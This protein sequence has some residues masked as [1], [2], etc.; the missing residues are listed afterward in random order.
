MHGNYGK[1]HSREWTK[2]IIEKSSKSL[3]GRKLSKEHI[4]KLRLKKIGNK[5]GCG[6]KGVKRSKEAIKNIREARKKQT[7]EN[8]W[9]WIKDRAKLKTDRLK[10]YDVKYK[11][12]MKEV[13]DRDNWKCKINN[14]DCNGRLEA[15]HILPWSKFPELRYEVNNGITLC[16]HHHPRKRNDEK[17]LAPMFKKMVLD[18]A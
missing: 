4:E 3:R 10:M 7:G 9:R 18:K 2:K 5:N 11:Y 16:L 17:I 12:W 6:N 15:H 14:K 8:H 1:K 13:K